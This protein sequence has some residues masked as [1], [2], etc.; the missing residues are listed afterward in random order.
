[1]NFCL[2]DSPDLGEIEVHALLNGRVWGAG[3]TG[4]TVEELMAVILWQASLPYV[5]DVAPYDAATAT[6]MYDAW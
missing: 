1:M 2:I 3:S 4:A 6:G 5:S